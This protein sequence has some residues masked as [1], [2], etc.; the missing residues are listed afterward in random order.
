MDLWISN[1]VDHTVVFIQASTYQLPKATLVRIAGQKG[2]GNFRD[3]DLST[4]L[5]NSPMSVSYYENKVYVADTLNHCI[6]VID[7]EVKSIKQFSG[8][9]TESGFK[10]GPPQYNRLYKPDLVGAANGTLFINDSGN[11]YIR[12]VDIATG[13]MKTL[14]GGAC[15][16]ANNIASSYS[17]P[18]YDVKNSVFYNDNG[19]IHTMVCDLSLIKTTGKPEEHI[20][21]INDYKDPC[22]M[23]ITLCENRTHPFVIRAFQA[24]Q[25][26]EATTTV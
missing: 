21:D 11:N 8:R 14:W 17:E 24:S 9:C 10:D 7:I 18:E 13:Y 22:F 23:H 19:S 12:I 3:G 26:S 20:F 25:V 1:P 6:R 2:I 4:A 5:L 15:R 16:D